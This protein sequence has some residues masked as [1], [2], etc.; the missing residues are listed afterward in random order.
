M[1]YL[2]YD[3]MEMVGSRPAAIPE[4]TTRAVAVLDTET[5]GRWTDVLEPSA[6]GDRALHWP[7]FSRAEALEHRQWLDARKGVV[8]PFWIPTFEPDLVLAADVSSGLSVIQV[9]W[10][11][12]SGL[13]WAGSN[14]RRHL[15]V[16]VPGQ[17]V[18]YHQVISAVDPGT[19]AAE[20]LIISPPAPCP[21]PADTTKISFL[22]FC[23]LSEP[24][25]DR[26][27]SGGHCCESVNPYVE[28]PREAPGGA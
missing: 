20:T 6:V 24:Y 10:I 3:V 25:V 27:W 23:R 9:Q 17:P 14:R 28:I 18:S 21:W 12:Y 11:Q 26:K 4:G 15:A 19:G 13:I 22:R 1:I 5:G 16:Y 7:A 8:V 2:G